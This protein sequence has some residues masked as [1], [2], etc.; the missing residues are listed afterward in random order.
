MKLAYLVILIIIAIA[1]GVGLA[2]ALGVKKNT[3]NVNLPEQTVSPA[4]VPAK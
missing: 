4:E 1:L 3:Y 2:V